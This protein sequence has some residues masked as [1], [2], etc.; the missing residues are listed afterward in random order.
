LA[1]LGDKCLAHEK[2]WEAT[3]NWMEGKIE[4]WKWGKNK[5]QN[6]ANL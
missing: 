1:K 2:W 5:K 4:Y 6:M 3:M